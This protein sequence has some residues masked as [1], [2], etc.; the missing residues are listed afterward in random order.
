[1]CV[2]RSHRLTK[3]PSMLKVQM[4]YRMYFS[5]Y[6]NMQLFKCT[7]TLCNPFTLTFRRFSVEGCVRPCKKHACRNKEGYNT[8]TFMPYRMSHKVCDVILDLT[9]LIKCKRQEHIAILQIRSVVHNNF[10]LQKIVHA[11]CN[12]SIAK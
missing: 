1:M 12:S 10:L 7:I 2:L 11:G 4:F 8:H 5:K 6:P 3:T 9:R